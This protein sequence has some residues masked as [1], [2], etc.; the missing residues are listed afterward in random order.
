MSLLLTLFICLMATRP[1]E[2]SVFRRNSLNLRSRQ[3]GLNSI[4]EHRD[5][6]GQHVEEEEEEVNNEEDDTA[7]ARKGP[8]PGRL[9][10]IIQQR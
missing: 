8:A 6:N 7:T 2:S 3:R 1:R 5:G 9:T 10:Q 4:N